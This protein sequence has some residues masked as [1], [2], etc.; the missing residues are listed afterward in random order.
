MQQNSA[1]ERDEKATLMTLHERTC[2]GFIDAQ[3]LWGRDAQLR[4]GGAKLLNHIWID[5]FMWSRFILR[6]RLI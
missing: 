1:D 5:L 6:R 4:K 2:L 3:F